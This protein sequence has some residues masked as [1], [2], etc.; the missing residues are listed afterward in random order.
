MTKTGDFKARSM[1][2]NCDQ[3]KAAVCH[4]QTDGLK[5]RQ[6]VGTSKYVQKSRIF[7]KYDFRRTDF[8]QIVRT[9]RKPGSC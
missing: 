4:S 7:Q 1:P 3:K 8:A 6:Q 9:I 5:S 2:H